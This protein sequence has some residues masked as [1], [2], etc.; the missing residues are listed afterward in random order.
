MDYPEIGFNF[1][2]LRRRGLRS[3]EVCDCWS[4]GHSHRDSLVLLDN[5]VVELHSVVLHYQG[6]GFSSRDGSEVGV[7]CKGCR[8][9]EIFL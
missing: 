1:R 7:C 9:E 8:C 6:E 2:I 4:G 3:L 5:D